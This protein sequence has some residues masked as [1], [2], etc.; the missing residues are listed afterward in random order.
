VVELSVGGARVRVADASP[1]AATASPHTLGGTCV[2]INLLVA[3]PDA[4]FQRALAAGATSVAPVADQ[5]YGL[6]QGRLTDPF[7]HD[8]LIGRPLAGPSGDWARSTGG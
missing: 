6:R 3:D 5:D 4:L 2:R 1:Q 8:W 7:G